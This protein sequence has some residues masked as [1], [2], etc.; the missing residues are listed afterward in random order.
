MRLKG[1]LVE[2]NDDRGFGFIEPADGGGR[3]FC[4]VKAFE[5]RVRRPMAGDRLT[6]ELSK[7]SDGRTSAARVRP[8]GLEDARYQSNVGT[9]SKS[10]RARGGGS[11]ARSIWKQ[12]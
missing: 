9:Q 3:V 8:M 6:Y 10:E 12:G 5:V 4:H 2:W 1:T 7:G 11:S